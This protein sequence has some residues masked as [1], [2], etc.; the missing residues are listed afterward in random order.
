MPFDGLLEVCLSG[1]SMEQHRGSRAPSISLRLSLLLEESPSICNA[2]VGGRV[3][4]D[5]SCTAKTRTEKEWKRA[6]E[7]GPFVSAGV[8]WRENDLPSRVRPGSLVR[9]G[10][11]PPPLSSSCTKND[12]L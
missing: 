1:V 11:M 6:F 12:F 9:D 5:P 8:N 7:F 4:D 2:K 10:V 3:I